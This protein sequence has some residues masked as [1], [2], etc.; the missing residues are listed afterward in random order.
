MIFQIKKIELDDGTFTY[1]MWVSRDPED[2]PE[3][4]KSFTNLTLATS[5]NSTMDRSNCSVGEVRINY[6]LG[7][8][9]F[10]KGKVLN[11]CSPSNLLPKDI[12]NTI[13]LR[14][15]HIKFIHTSILDLHFSK[16]QS[17]CYHLL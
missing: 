3:Y 2:A 5:F 12:P 16:F 15:Y 9:N 7:K 14:K 8:S 1:C 11:N 4:G 6:Q 17:F 10:S 13:S